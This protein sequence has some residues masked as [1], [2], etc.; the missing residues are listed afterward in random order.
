MAR[1]HL[2][3]VHLRL[4]ADFLE[5]GHA[6]VRQLVIEVL[7]HRI[8]VEV[9]AMLS[10][11]W[12]RQP[13]PPHHVANFVEKIGGELAALDLFADLLGLLGVQPLQLAVHVGQK[14]TQ[15]QSHDRTSIYLY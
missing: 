1:S 5:V 12:R 14:C 8:A 10:D 6:V 7:G 4:Q 15:R 13:Q 11:R 2:G 9:R 3:Q